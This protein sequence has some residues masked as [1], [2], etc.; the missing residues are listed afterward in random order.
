MSSDKKRSALNRVAARVRQSNPNLTH[1]QA[2]RVVEKHL[3]R[4]DRKQEK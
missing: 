3:E 4:Y 2:R 1:D